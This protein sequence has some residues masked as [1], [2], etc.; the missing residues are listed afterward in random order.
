MSQPSPWNIVQTSAFDPAAR[1]S[2]HERLRDIR[3]ACPVMRDEPAKT[4]LLTGYDE[5]RAIVNDR[6]LWRNSR[7]A[8][9]GSLLKRPPPPGENPAETILTLDEPDHSRVRPPLA[10]AFYARIN[11]MRPQ[12]EAVIDGVIDGLPEHDTFD[13]IADLA[14]PIPI[15][16]IAAIL[17]VE[18]TR[19]GEFR[20]WSEAAILGLN[21]LRTPEQTERMTWGVAELSAYFSALMAERRRE[22]RDDLISDL[23]RLQAEGAPLSDDEVRVNLTALLIGGNLTTTDLIGNGIWLLLTHPD[24]LA[25][26]RADPELVGACVEEILRYE[27]PVGVTSRVM[28]REE[29]MQGQRLCP[30]QSVMVSL[31]AANRDPKVFSDPDRF[32]I[33]RPHAPHVAFGGGAHICIGAPLARLEAKH[34]LLRIL[35]RWPDLKLR[36]DALVWRALPFFRGIERLRVSG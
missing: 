19:V 1:A 35:E 31:H 17:G 7:H 16:V 29:E 34:A 22:P 32:D 6:S 21:P 33:T 26:L 15:L 20:A 3:E 18:S 14:I 25:K 12:I 30:H 28:N 13:L 4:W 11:A 23:V 24:E 27:G 8:E 2:P 36:E 10:R 5:V 9:D